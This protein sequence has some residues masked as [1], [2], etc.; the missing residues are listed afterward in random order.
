[1]D[2]TPNET[3][4]ESPE[5]SAP[6]EAAAPPAPTDR[7]RQGK[8][9]LRAQS[10][11][12]RL[13]P[14]C[15]TLEL[16][17][18]AAELRQGKLRMA[19]AAV[20]VLD[21]RNGVLAVSDG[22]RWICLDATRCRDSAGP[23]VRRDGAFSPSFAQL[24]VDLGRALPN[25]DRSAEPRLPGESFAFRYAVRVEL[26]T[27]VL[28][29]LLIGLFLA[30]V[31]WAEG[32]MES[33][34]DQRGVWLFAGLCAAAAG[35][36]YLWRWLSSAVFDSEGVAIRRFGRRRFHPWGRLDALHSQGMEIELES[37]RLRLSF[38]LDVL[39]A[40]RAPLI[41]RR[42]I[43]PYI[44][45]LGIRFLQWLRQRVQEVPELPF[46]SP[47]AEILRAR[48]WLAV[49]VGINIYF[50]FRSQPPGWFGEADAANGFFFEKRLI[51]LG[52]RTER[53]FAEPWRFFSAL[54][55]HGSAVHLGL[56]MFILASV[57]PWLLRVYGFWRGTLH[58]LGSGTLGNVLAQLSGYL[59]FGFGPEPGRPSV[60]VGSSTA[61]LGIVGSLLG[62]VYHRPHSVPLV[63]RARFRWAIPLTV[64][65]TIASGFAIVVLDNA[66]HLGG[67]LAG[68]GLAWVIPPRRVDGGG[69][70]P[71]RGTPAERPMP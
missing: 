44:T 41:L 71:A 65:L 33:R 26:G 35:A 22:R 53:S 31:E 6:G 47:A 23:V 60:S 63:I 3:P 64:V 40:G 7:G 27:I 54:F 19:F 15:R 13:R 14:A 39:R 56:N 57:A 10:W 52:A 28:S 1:M 61:I 69:P 17:F 67:F 34:I 36:L 8:A 29:V 24:L 2:A 50:F 59:P 9:R 18:D 5:P 25:L 62:A 49:L 12:G 42:G 11:I 30:D 55:L 16:D 21:L 43:R 45:P 70:R 38:N 32:G 48:L 58:Y 20:R 4:Q 37:R 46:A 51:A 68:L 66:A